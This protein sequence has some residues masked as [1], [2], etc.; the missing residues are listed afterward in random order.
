MIQLI[1]KFLIL[2]TIFAAYF[3]FVPS[4]SPVYAKTISVMKT[5]KAIRSSVV[6]RYSPI[7]IS[8]CVDVWQNGNQY[9]VQMYDLKR[10]ET[11][12]LKEYSLFYKS[13]F[14]R[15]EMSIPTKASGDKL[16]TMSC[17]ILEFID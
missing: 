12:I 14:Y 3:I 5:K 8:K 7:D 13:A 15:L 4:G 10:E 9:H 2:F 6:G 11:T 1:M 17:F 16:Q